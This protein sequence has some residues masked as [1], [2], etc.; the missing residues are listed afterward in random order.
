MLERAEFGVSAPLW[1][2]TGERIAEAELT[3]F[4]RAAARIAHRD[5]ASYGDLHQWSIDDCGAFWDLVWEELGVVGDRIGV[6]FKPGERMMDAKF[7]P[8]SRLNFTENLLRRT[9]LADAIVSY[10]ELQVARRLS[11]DQLRDQVLRLRQWLIDH[12]V[13]AGDRVAAIAPN[14]PEAIVGMLATVS[15]GAIWSSCSP[16]LGEKAVIARFG[17]IEP[18]VLI[19]TGGCLLN[20]EQCDLVEKM[21]DI[22]DRLPTVR[23]GLLI[24]D[25]E[26]PAGRLQRGVKF[27]SF[28]EIVEN[29]QPAKAFYE[30]FPFGQ[31]LSILYSSG[32]TGLPKCLLHSAGGTLLQH[33]KEHRLHCDIR[34][35][36]RVFFATTCGWMMWN[37]LV[38]TLASGATVVLYDGSPFE[39]DGLVLFDLIESERLTHFGVS[40][41]FI[42]ACRMMDLAPEQTHDLSSMR[43]V[44]STGS[45]LSRRCFEYVYASIK[46]DVHLASISGGT[47]IVS[48]FAMGVPTGPVWAGE[49]QGPALGMAVDVYDED[50]RPL[51]RGAGE[52]VCTRP[53]PSMP[54]QFWNDGAGERYR[55]SYF[56]RFPGVWTHG[57]FAEWAEHAGLAIHGRSD[58]TLKPGGIRIGTAEIYALVGSLP[59][60]ADA[61]CVGQEWD[62]DIRIVLFVVLK[63]GTNLDRPLERRIRDTIASGAS[64]HHVPA[65]ICQVRDIPRTYSGKTS[66]LAVKDALARRPIRNIEALVNPQCLSQFEIVDPSR[67]EMDEFDM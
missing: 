15:L 3:R 61:V 40:A 28:N 25:S 5:F 55:A 4:S 13:K 20:G 46:R 63:D 65:V 47:D 64:V 1:T 8:E 18:V 21:R 50:G 48:C 12:D 33:L 56:E 62:G 41:R 31:P 39:N 42:D 35:G 30:R 44:L 37:W 22:I 66:E 7:F 10:T 16:D 58:A 32:T 57:D 27:E 6:P 36:D 60:I 19:G 59:E 2:P 29:Y 45:P 53:F 52:L 11:W 38:S 34:A 24:E 51:R 43:A 23:C 49:I 26:P 17:Q 9:G 67:D 14:V 54:L